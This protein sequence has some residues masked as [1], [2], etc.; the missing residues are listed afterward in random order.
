MKKL[1]FIALLS[2]LLSVSIFAD[3]AKFTVSSI[4][5]SGR[6]YYHCDVVEKMTEDL[7][8]AFGAT[9]SKM[10]CS[11]GYDSMDPR[12]SRDAQV[13]VSFD[14]PRD[15]SVR[16]IELRGRDN[17]HLVNE[18]FDGIKEHF[19]LTDVSLSSCGFRPG[20]G[21]SLKA[22]VIAQ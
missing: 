21:W 12:W 11:G 8:E 19:I 13:R 9:V 20:R 15:G 7:L 17:C 14:K 5:N 6:T 10:R 16:D 18:V 1:A 4:T 22:T 3:S 2:S